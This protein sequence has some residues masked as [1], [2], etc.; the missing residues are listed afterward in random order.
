MQR[1]FLSKGILFAQRF[2]RYRHRSTK[3]RS[4][5]KKPKQKKAAEMSNEESEQLLE[6]GADSPL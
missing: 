6:A 2:C 4:R 5:E 3:K 1:F